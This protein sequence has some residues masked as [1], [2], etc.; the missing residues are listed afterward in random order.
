MN[1]ENN[2]IKTYS[3]GHAAQMLNCGLGRNQLY[4]LLKANYIIQSDNT[5]FIQYIRKGY[6]QEYSKSYKTKYNT[7]KF[8]RLTLVTEEG[9]KWL[10]QF[11]SDKLNLVSK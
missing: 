9:M 11:V 3:M 7:F 5:P 8:H 6:F 10:R 2:I 4:E 1:S